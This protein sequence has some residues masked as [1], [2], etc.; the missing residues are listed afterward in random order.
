MNEPADACQAYYDPVHPRSD[1]DERIL[2]N[3]DDEENDTFSS[4]VALDDVTGFRGS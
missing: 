2:D 3:N 1:N 4:Y